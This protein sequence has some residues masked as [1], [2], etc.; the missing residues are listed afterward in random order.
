MDAAVRPN[1]ITLQTPNCI[2]SAIDILGSLSTNMNGV[3]PINSGRNSC[4]VLSFSLSRS[5]IG[6]IPIGWRDCFV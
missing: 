2:N 6:S 4:L 5:S 3:I 1:A